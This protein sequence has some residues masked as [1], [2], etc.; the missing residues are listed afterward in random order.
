MLHV[1]SHFHTL[2]Q[3]QEPAPPKDA[4]ESVEVDEPNPKAREL[5][6]NQLSIQGIG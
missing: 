5:Q 1:N 3:S 6:R 2:N 4:E